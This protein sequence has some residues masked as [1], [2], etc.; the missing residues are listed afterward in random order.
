MFLG[1]LCDKL[2]L[3]GVIIYIKFSIEI[4]LRNL[5]E[6]VVEVDGPKEKLA[7]KNMKS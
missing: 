1:S 7:K 4:P 6:E 2:T 3:K 5:K